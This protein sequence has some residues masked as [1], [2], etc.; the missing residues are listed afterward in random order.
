MVKITYVHRSTREQIQ[1]QRTTLFVFGDNVARVGYGGQAREARGEPNT[2]G[3]ATLYAPYNYF[4]KDI[5][6]ELKFI[7]SDLSRLE[8]QLMKGIDVVAPFD[9]VGTGLSQ[10]SR[11]APSLYNNI[12]LWFK[13]RDSDCPWGCV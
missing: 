3:I 5:A 12:V 1:R 2:L 7:Q 4:G 6:R 9:G 11:L 10:L 8:E 13:E